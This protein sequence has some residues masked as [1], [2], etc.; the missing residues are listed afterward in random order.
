SV[1]LPTL[2][3]SLPLFPYTTLFRSTNHSAAGAPHRFAADDERLRITLQRYFGRL[4]NLRLGTR[5]R[6]PRT[7]ECVGRVPSA[8]SHRLGL[9]S[10]EHTSELQSPCNLV[11]RLLLE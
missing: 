7:R 10:E 2:P 3:S 5:D 4:R 1:R 8:R 6:V 9:R 11:S